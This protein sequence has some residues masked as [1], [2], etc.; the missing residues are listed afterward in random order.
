[1]LQSSLLVLLCALLWYTYVTPPGHVGCP[2]SET[3]TSLERAPGQLAEIA[4]GRTYYRLQG[5]EANELVVLVHGFSSQSEVSYEF[6]VEPLLQAQYRV[7]YYDLWGRGHSDAPLGVTYDAT[8]FTHQLLDLLEH[9]ELS[10]E[11]IHLVGLSMGGAVSIHFSYMYPARVRSLTLIS[12]AGLPLHK[13]W[14]S[15]LVERLPTFIGWPLFRLLSP[16]QLGKFIARELPDLE[17][18]TQREIFASY[19][20]SLHINLEHNEGFLRAL[21]RTVVDFPMESMQ[22]QLT[23]IGS[24]PRRVLLLWG[25]EDVAIPLSCAHQM[26]E[27]LPNARLVTIAGGS[28]VAV[29]Q[30]PRFAADTI[31]QFLRQ[32]EDE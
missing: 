20:R 7:L 11:R 26:L 8:L 31:L 19:D 32:L 23:A 24:D 21:Y 2:L 17:Q 29:A 5:D 13:P 3:V 4:G 30:Q 27:T 28:H 18:Q 1:M 12:S 22:A 10:C 9:L 6:L 25:E 16:S 14:A 15:R